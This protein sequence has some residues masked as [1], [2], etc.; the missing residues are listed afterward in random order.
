MI[1]VFILSF[2]RS[3]TAWLATYLNHG[4]VFAFH[5]A[6][7][8]VK[9]VKQLR[10]RMESKSK[11]GG[12][13]VNVDCSNWFFL[14]ELQDEFPD[15]LYIRINRDVAEVEASARESFGPQ[16]YT[17]M[18]E[19]YERAIASRAV[20]PALAVNFSKWDE[21]ESLNIWNLI[22]DHGH[23]D[24]DWH[25]QMHDL[26]IQLTPDAVREELRM[27]EAGELLHLSRRMVA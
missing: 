11:H 9:T 17:G 10:V 13:V 19:A 12:P 22:T 3:R 18:F 16:D 24:S 7:K 14:K 6:F 15:A 2:P 8:L 1:P 4:N 23:M 5:E 21:M 20:M 26:W 25:R 27:G